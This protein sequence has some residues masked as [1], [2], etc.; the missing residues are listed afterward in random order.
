M[1]RHYYAH[2][3]QKMVAEHIGPMLRAAL[4]VGA[5]S[6]PLALP[7]T[8]QQDPTVLMQDAGQLHNGIGV[9]QN[10]QK[11]F[12]L[13]QKAADLGHVDA[14]NQVGK[15][16]FEGRGV[17]PDPEAALVWLRAAAQAGNPEH[18]FDLAVALEANGLPEEAAALYQQAAA[19]DHLDAIVSLGVLHQN[20]TGLPQDYQK[21]FALYVIAADAGHA[22]AQNNLGLLFVR[23]HGVPQDYAQAVALFT[24]SAEQGLTQAMTNLGV[25]YDNGFGVP[26]NDATAAQWYRLGGRGMA[27]R[28]SSPIYDARLAPPPNT[29]AGRIATLDAARLGDPVAQYL[30]GWLLL[31]RAEPGDIQT[32]AQWFTAAAADGHVVSMA[33]LARLHFL[34]QGVLQDYVTGQ[35]WA[36]LA[37]AGGLEHANHIAQDVGVTLSPEQQAAA[38]ELAAQKWQ[39]M[40][41]GDARESP[42]EI[43]SK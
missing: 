32:A 39:V 34:G 11:A 37:L 4:L 30:A 27:G 7:A 31:E 13:Y 15:Y 5:A 17:A 26:Q 28:Q 35:M 1:T 33:N 2:F 21:A 12:A 18:V 41:P 20:G 6:L 3:L 24:A 10:H 8:A 25:M 14:Q 43:E 38:Q 29:D 36:I 9:P 40:Q 16:L 23:G 19:S 42:L 22:R